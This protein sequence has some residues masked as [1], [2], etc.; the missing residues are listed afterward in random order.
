MNCFSLFFPCHEGSCLHVTTI[1][2]GWAFCFLL[3]D[4]SYLSITAIKSYN[5]IMQ[6]NLITHQLTYLMSFII[7]E[8]LLWIT[9]SWLQEL[10]WRISIRW[11][12]GTVWGHRVFPAADKR[13]CGMHPWPAP[14]GSPPTIFGRAIFVCLFCFV[15]VCLFYILIVC[16]N[17]CVPYVIVKIPKLIFEIWVC[18]K[19]GSIFLHRLNYGTI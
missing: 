7:S 12:R 19:I 17:E 11:Q 6:Q 2:L 4:K 18:S 13:V 1:S 5:L 15:C 16:K 3:I 10:V 8:C 14:P 9:S